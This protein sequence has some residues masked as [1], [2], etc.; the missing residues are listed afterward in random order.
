MKI[1]IIV[2]LFFAVFSA[3]ASLWSLNYQGHNL[4]NY[5][6]NGKKLKISK[7][8]GEAFTLEH[9]KKYLELR[10]KGKGNS[11]FPIQWKLVNLSTGE[12]IDQSKSIDKV[13][14]GASSTKIMVGSAF[15][16]KEH[17]P[18]ESIYFQNLLDMIVVS[19]NSAWKIV[20][21]AIGNGDME[22]GRL[23]IHQFTKDLGLDRTRGYWG[24]SSSMNGLHGNEINVVEFMKFM[25]LLY[26]GEFRGSELIFKIMLTGQKGY[27]MAKRLLPSDVMIANK[28]GRCDCR[29]LNP[30]TESGTYPDGTPFRVYVR[31]QSLFLRH[32]N[33]DY[34]MV[35]LSD[36]G[37]E[38]DLS[39]M[40]AGLFYEFIN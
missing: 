17:N 30:D 7:G 21:K 35:I 39:V 28:G 23:F 2:S 1:L 5:S 6:V 26:R 27:D 16:Q 4:E 11:Y 22:K 14:Y 34:A 10:K 25:E 32:D 13:F 37:E 18:F 31:H 8:K 38:I 29:T 19:S 40:A 15:L 24:Y 36:L 12:T 20:Q 33:V 9:Q 3:K